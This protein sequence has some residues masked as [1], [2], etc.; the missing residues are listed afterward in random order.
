[1]CIPRV[2]VIYALIRKCSCATMYYF[3]FVC[4]LR[5]RETTR[6]IGADSE[7]WV[8][9]VHID[10]LHVWDRFTIRDH[11]SPMYA[12]NLTRAVCVMNASHCPPAPYDHI[13]EGRGAHSL[14]QTDSRNI[15]EG[16]CTVRNV[17]CVIYL[18]PV[19]FTRAQY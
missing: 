16:P 8:E 9:S 18:C 19:C 2:C 15:H 1:M 4:V 12:T 13:D 14:Q 6:G 11:T 17:S 7:A 10:F 3:A 5:L